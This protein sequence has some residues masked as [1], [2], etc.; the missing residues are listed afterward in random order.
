MRRSGHQPMK[1]AITHPFCW[2]HVRRGSERQIEII[3]TWL[4]GRGHDVTYFSTHPEREIVEETSYG[5]R[6]LARSMRGIGLLNIDERH[7]FLLTS[8]RRLT[9][10]D[11]EIVHSF[12]YT[13][14]L[15]ASLR[16]RNNKFRT[17]LQLHGVAVPGVSCHRFLPPEAYMLGEAFRRAD[18]TVTCSRFIAAQMEAI[19]GVKAR[20]I[21]S[22][23]DIDAWTLGDG[24]PGDRPV[25]LA[26]ADFTV[27]RKGVRPLVRAFSRVREVHP[28][29]ILQLSGRMTKELESELR[30]LA[31]AATCEGIEF[32]GMGEPGDLP[33]LYRQASLLALPA[34]FEPSGGSMMEA[35]A[36]GAP[37]VAAGHG[38][39]P[40]Y[41]E[42]EV[43]VLV[44]PLGDGEEL[45][46]IEGLAEGLL[47]GIELSRTPGIRQRCRAYAERYSVNAL[48]G[49]FEDLYASLS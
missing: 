41:L 18:A 32:L 14:S 19:Y 15:A 28:G 9:S 40:E 2:P 27:R 5:R 47:S 24:P 45:S 25:I 29:A 37:V 34:M 6:V 10:S 21:S 20:I 39:L 17:I 46:N 35:L 43:S 36:S 8:L 48:G 16:R 11:A 38:G 4:G 22:A 31:G 26:A 33:R 1:I 13:D 23:V 12:Y 30:A 44:D 49:H 42:P 3:A 7:T